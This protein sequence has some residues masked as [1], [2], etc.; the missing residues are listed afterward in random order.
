MH[1][2]YTIDDIA[3][4]TSLSTRTIR[5]YLRMGLLDGE[6]IDGV[7]QFTAEDFGRFLQQDMVRQSLQAKSLG[8]LYDFLRQP[9]DPGVC[10]VIDLA[11]GEDEPAQ[12]QR[13]LDEVNRCGR[14]RLRYSHE[15]RMS[16]AIV[17]GPL[18]DVAA[19]LQ[20]IR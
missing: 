7:W 16:R 3:G 4:M 9:K 14:L 6:K 20:A 2:Y 10:A 8:L 17:S 11:A 15:G 19:L 1:E 18:E 13:L 5:N 12:R